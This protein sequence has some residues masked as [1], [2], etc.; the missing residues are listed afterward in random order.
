MGL[1]SNPMQSNGD[2]FLLSYSDPIIASHT[3]VESMFVGVGHIYQTLLI[4]HFAR[5][6]TSL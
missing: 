6:K 2:G 4:S 5:V 3:T 1:T